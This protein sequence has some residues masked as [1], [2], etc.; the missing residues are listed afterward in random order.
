LSFDEQNRKEM[1]KDE[2][3]LDL[4]VVSY[5]EGSASRTFASAEGILYQLRDDLHKNKKYASV[6][7]WPCD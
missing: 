2:E 3:L 5:K 6:G 4:V 7:E 1:T